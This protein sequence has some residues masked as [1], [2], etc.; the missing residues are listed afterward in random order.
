MR[1]LQ[2]A[3]VFG[4]VLHPCSECGQVQQQK[5]H[6]NSTWLLLS[7]PKQI[8]LL[9]VC[10]WVRVW[11]CV[12]RGKCVWITSP[13]KWISSSLHPLDWQTGQPITPWLA[14]LLD[15]VMHQH[16]T[17]RPILFFSFCMD[18]SPLRT[19]PEPLTLTRSGTSTPMGHPTPAYLEGRAKLLL[20]GQRWQGIF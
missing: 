20:D 7:T 12:L 9:L 2:P 11:K 8:S 18:D 4:S 1:C 6:S 10:V 19:N 13:F 5:K 17:P 3:S 16:S 15:P 14:F